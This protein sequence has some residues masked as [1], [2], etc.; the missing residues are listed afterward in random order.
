MPL[1]AAGL[2]FC[3]ALLF[4][5]CWLGAWATFIWAGFDDGTFPLPD[6]LVCA[7]LAALFVRVSAG[8]RLRNVQV[9]ALHVA[10]V[11]AF[12]LFELQRYNGTLSLMLALATAAFWTSG[13]L[14][15][16][17]TLTHRVVCAR[18][19]FGMYWLLALLGLRVL[20]RGQAQVPQQAELTDA[21]VPSFFVNAL[22]AI[23]VARFRSQGS[24]QWLRVS[25]RIVML[26]SGLSALGTLGFSIT[27]M[28]RPYLRS[29]AATTHSGA[30]TVIRPIANAA[31]ELLF[32]VMRE[33]RKHPVPVYLPGHLPLRYPGRKTLPDEPLQLVPVDEMTLTA[34]CIAGCVL[35]LIAAVFWLW[36]KRQWLFAEQSQREPESDLWALCKQLWRRALAWFRALRGSTVEE[37]VR[38][39]NALLIWGERSGVTREGAETPLEYARRLKLSFAAMGGEIDSIVRNHCRQIYALGA[40][41]EAELRETRHALRLL[42]SPRQWWARSVSRWRAMHARQH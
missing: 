35:A 9:L 27:W 2:L 39:M 20:L 25:G 16:R 17:R 12:W 10:C 33:G 32:A 26:F 14:H 22:C 15:A 23:C 7:G 41:D 34:L 30:A 40:C 21:L 18:F 42:R 5:L 37:P 29:L 3:S 13:A 4:E 38:L 6:M 36:W 1:I 24:K 11:S 19:D 28:C 31:A 8:K